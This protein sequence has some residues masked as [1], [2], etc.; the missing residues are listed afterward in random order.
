M[1]WSKG[2]VRWRDPEDSHWC[3]SVPFTWKL[4]EAAAFAVRHRGTIVGGPAVRLMPEY[5]GKYAQVDLD[6]IPGVYARH[7][8][9][10]TVTTRG[11]RNH[12]PFCAVARIEGA[13]REIEGFTPGAVV[14]DSNL[15]QCSPQHLERVMTMLEGQHDVDFNGGLEAELLDP[16]ICA[17]I[18]SLPS[19]KRVQLSWDEEGDESSVLAAIDELRSAGVVAAKITCRVLV[20]FR[21]SPGAAALRMMVLRQARVKPFP[22][23]Y[24]PLDT[25]EKNSYKAPQWRGW[26]LK[27]FVRFWSRQ[28]WLTG[29]A[30]DWD[31]CA[32]EPE[33]PE[34]TQGVLL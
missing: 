12:C 25:L 2:I 10:C 11:C 31:A 15:L 17:R 29:V 28:A 24:Q 13:Y 9:D 3:L 4:K 14:I 23:R 27:Q 21:E 1:S 8:P 22:M 5:I 19:L 30:W 16:H 32:P 18:A 20:N 7:N 33:P 26:P 34:R 6:D